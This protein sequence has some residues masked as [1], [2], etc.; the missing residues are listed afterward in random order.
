MPSKKSEL[1]VK[2]QKDLQEKFNLQPDME[3][4]GKVTDGLGPSIY[5]RDSSTV[6]GSDVKELERVKTNFLIKK[7][8]LADSPELMEAIEAVIKQYGT[9]VRTKYRAVVYYQLTKHFGKEGVY[10]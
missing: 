1:I 2:Y 7:L 4:L 10:N 9:S 5:N 3:L 6:S 8:G